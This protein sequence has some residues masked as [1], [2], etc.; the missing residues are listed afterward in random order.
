M[1]E[2]IP[3]IGKV[4]LIF[5]LVIASIGV[6]SNALAINAGYIYIISTLACIGEVVALVYMLKG[7]PLPYL[8]LYIG[9]YLINAILVVSLQNNYSAPSVVGYIIGLLLNIG[10]TYSSIKNTI[11]KK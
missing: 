9:C 4:W 8:Y 7:K 5:I 6:I 2:K 10:L 3:T 11:D 1:S